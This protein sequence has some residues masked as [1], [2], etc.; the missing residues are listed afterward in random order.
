MVIIRKII[1]PNLVTK[2]YESQRIS[3]SFYMFGYLVELNIEFDDSIFF[4]KVQIWESKTPK[5]N[6]AIFEK[7]SPLLYIVVQYLATLLQEY[8]KPISFFMFVRRGL[9]SWLLPL[10]FLPPYC[11]PMILLLLL[12]NLPCIGHFQACLVV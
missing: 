8:I 5:T 1:S 10:N 7:K 9:V 2:I 12:S 4:L 11:L 3:T 6:F